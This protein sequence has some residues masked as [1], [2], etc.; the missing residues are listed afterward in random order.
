MFKALNLSVPLANQLQVVFLNIRNVYE[1]QE[2]PSR[3]YSWPALIMS[4]ILVEIPCSI[5]G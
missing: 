3:T 1:I 4:Q 5:L 2:R